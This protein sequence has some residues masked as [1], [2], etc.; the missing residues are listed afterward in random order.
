MQ[1]L[2]LASVLITLTQSWVASANPTG[3]LQKREPQLNPSTASF[4][5]ISKAQMPQGKTTILDW[6]YA[7]KC[8]KTLS[9]SF[10][11][12]SSTFRRPHTQPRCH[13]S[14]HPELFLCG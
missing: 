3:L 8:T 10:T 13:R 11:S 6:L 4:C 5:D 9:C 2:L 1:I 12:S 7:T 14:R